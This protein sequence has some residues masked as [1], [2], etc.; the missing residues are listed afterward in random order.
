M[1]FRQSDSLFAADTPSGPLSFEYSPINILPFKY[2]PVAIITAFTLYTAPRSVLIAS[3]LP[4]STLISTISPCFTSRFSC[5][6]KV[7]FISAW[8]FFLSAC[9]LNECTAGPLD[10]FS[11]F[12]C[13]IVLSIFF[14]ISPPRASISLTKCPLELPPICGL[15]GIFAIASKLI[16]NISVF[17]PSL[18]DASPAS[19]PACPAPITATSYSPA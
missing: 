6:S 1:F 5:F 9:A 13:I 2:V 15:H 16:E 10:V 12:I 18:A 19:Q 7:C 8:Y 11:I 4:F 3:T 17:I 14:P